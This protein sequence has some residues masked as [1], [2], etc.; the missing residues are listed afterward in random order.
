[1]WIAVFW[2]WHRYYKLR[3]IMIIC[4]ILYKV[5]TKMLCHWWKLYSPGSI[6]PYDLFHIGICYFWSIVALFFLTY[7]VTK[8]MLP[9][10]LCDD[11]TRDKFLIVFIELH[12]PPL[13]SLSS[14]FPS[15]LFHDSHAPWLLRRSWVFFSFLCRNQEWFLSPWKCITLYGL[16]SKILWSF[17]KYM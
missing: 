12:F 14:L 17:L 15:A 13:P 4:I 9:F 5:K 10:T 11:Q 1:M 8:L 2:E 16:V 3:A 6:F 7:S